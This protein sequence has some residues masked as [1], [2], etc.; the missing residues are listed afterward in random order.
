MQVVKFNILENLLKGSYVGHVGYCRNGLRKKITLGRN[1]Q[2]EIKLST[3]KI[4]HGK[5]QIT[6]KKKNLIEESSLLKK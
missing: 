2:H 1:N 6:K 3:A 5:I 4:A